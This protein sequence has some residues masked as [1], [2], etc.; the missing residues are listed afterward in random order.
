ML[1]DHLQRQVRQAGNHQFP[2]ARH[3]A[4]ASYSRMISQ[5]PAGIPDP[6]RDLARRTRL[7]PGDVLDGSVE[8]VQ[9]LARPLNPHSRPNA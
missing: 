1:P 8:I 5:L 4:R 6:L 2:R 3:T 7:V 9:S